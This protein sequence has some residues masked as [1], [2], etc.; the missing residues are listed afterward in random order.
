MGG[1]AVPQ[2][3]GF[4]GLSRQEGKVMAPERAQLEQLLN[5][6]Y[7][8]I[9]RT[10]DAIFWLTAWP[11]VA[12]AADIT[13]LLF[14]G[15]WDMWADWKDRQ[16]WITITPFAMIIIP[17]ALQ[18]IQWR[19]WRMPTGATY[20]ATGLFAAAWIGRWVQWDMLINYPLAFVW[21][22]TIVPAG[23]L[24]DWVLFKTKGSFVI[25]S[26]VGSLVWT[27]AIWVANYSTLAPLLQPVEYMGNI[28]T[29]ADVQ[30]I[31]Y[32][33]T[34]TPEYLRIIEHGTLRSFLQ[35]TTLVSILFGANVAIA[36]YWI[37]QYIGRYLAVWP[38]LRFM[39][40]Y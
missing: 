10:W 15:D 12:A 20:T 21:P 2:V 13:K 1:G 6:K 26:V 29:V 4:L 24:M 23:I 17:S 34:Q 11:I 40:T 3:G 27:L 19:A 39:K 36:G 9:D 8:Y 7:R 16:W 5:R 33:R 25:T 31:A 28:L 22:A 14:A 32:L 30:G 18:Y 37:G 35:E 38:I